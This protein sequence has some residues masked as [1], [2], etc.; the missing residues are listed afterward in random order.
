MTT[1][2]AASS[3]P[4][5]PLSE[6]MATFADEDRRSAILLSLARLGRELGLFVVGLP[7]APP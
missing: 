7:Q 4:W 5:Q 1:D 2:P 6:R 3:T